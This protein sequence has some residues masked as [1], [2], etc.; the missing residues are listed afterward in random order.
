MKSNVKT[1]TTT[2]L[3]QE[4]AKSN[5]FIAVRTG[6]RCK[7]TGEKGKK[8][9]VQ[10]S[11]TYYRNYSSRVLSGGGGI[12]YSRFSLTCIGTPIHFIPIVGMGKRG[13]Y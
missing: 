8:S 4:L 3:L 11:I 9:N 2:I 7:S 5:Y 12:A 6:K 10:C 1:A 13:E